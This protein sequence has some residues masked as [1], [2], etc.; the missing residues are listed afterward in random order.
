[1]HLPVTSFRA[2]SIELT[3]EDLREIDAAASR[4]QVQSA[5]YPERSEQMTGR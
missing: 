3:P 4:S 1:M 5:R 2:V